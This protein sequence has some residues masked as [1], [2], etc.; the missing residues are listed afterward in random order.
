[1]S[2]MPDERF[3]ALLRAAVRFASEALLL[4]W[5]WVCGG[6][7]VAEEVRVKWEAPSWWI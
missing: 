7:D 6:F 4:W 1:M 5:V 2:T 3:V